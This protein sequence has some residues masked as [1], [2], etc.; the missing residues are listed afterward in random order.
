MRVDAAGAEGAKVIRLGKN[1][2]ARVVVG[3]D[4]V[5]KVVHSPGQPGEFVR[6]MPRRVRIKMFNTG[7]NL[8][9]GD[10]DPHWQC[11]ARSDDAKFKPR[12]AVVTDGRDR[13]RVTNQSDRSQWISA[14]GGGGTCPTASYTPFAR[15]S[16]LRECGHRRPICTGDSWSTITCVRFA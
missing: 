16:I 10:R 5:A 6:Q 12:P 3:K 4:R 11:V 13:R 2:S 8:K 9:D 15:R 14:V 7:M 1:E